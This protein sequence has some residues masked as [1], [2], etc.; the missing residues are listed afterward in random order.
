MTLAWGRPMVAIPGPSVI[1][2]QVLAAMHRPMTNIYEGELVDL[3]HS[4]LDDLADV[5]RTEHRPFLSIS[6]GH[7]AWEMVITNTLSRGDR[8]LVAATGHF[9]VAWGE[10][11]QRLGIVVDYV[12][13]PLDQAFDPTELQA[14]LEADRTYRAVLCVQVDTG[15]SVMNDI[16][17]FRRALDA[18]DHPAMLMVDCI[19][20]LGC[21]PFEMDA[22]G[23]DVTVASTQ[24]GLMV[25][26]GL[27]IVWAGPRALEAH[28][29]AGLRTAYWDWTPRLD[30]EAPFYHLFAGT[31]PVSHLFGMRAALDLLLAEGVEAAWARHDVFA[32]SVHA[33]VGAWGDGVDGLSLNVADPTH[34]APSVTTILTGAGIDG[35]ALRE[36]A[37]RSAG[38]TLG[39]P[40][41]AFDGRAFRIGHMG[42]LNPPMLLGTLTTVEAVLES[43]GAPLGGSG[44]AAAA[45]VVGEALA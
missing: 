9:A 29:T 5:A 27:G 3:T 42:H 40:V 10:V 45:G 13:S 4:V 21:A 18:A 38:L 12:E 39:I 23:V 26:P 6:N 32:R 30:P 24:K 15:T 7:G 2:D 28:R 34:R 1:P 36:R 35:A 17:A 16:A 41:G 20:S 19:A 11:A 37:E 8:V 25:P 33:A 14:R 43:L 44:A 22:W 31:P